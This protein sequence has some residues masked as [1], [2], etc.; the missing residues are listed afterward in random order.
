MA[1]YRVSGVSPSHVGRRKQVCPA[2]PTRQ[3][4]PVRQ[5]DSEAFISQTECEH[6]DR[7]DTLDATANRGHLVPTDAAQWFMTS[8]PRSVVSS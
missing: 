8:S 7:V 3:T 4:T 1:T 6:L 2:L 5:N